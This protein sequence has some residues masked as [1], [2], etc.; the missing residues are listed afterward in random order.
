MVVE[1]SITQVVTH[2]AIE[3]TK[4]AIM[5]V[6]AGDNLVNNA[7]PIHTMLQFGGQALRH[8]MGKSQINTK[9]CHPLK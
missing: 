9:N 2:M 7:I 8:L 6:R 4:A 1:K 3:A 5:V